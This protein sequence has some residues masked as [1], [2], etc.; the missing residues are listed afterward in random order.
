MSWKVEKAIA[1]IVK[2]F[3]RNK[4][5][6]FQE[7]ID[8]LKI[9]AENYTESKNETVNDNLLFA[10]LVSL[11]LTQNI[12][13]YGSIELAVERLRSDLELSFNAHV[14]TLA[15]TINNHNLL[16]YFNSIGLK[17]WKNEKEL[18]ENKTII[19]EHQKQMIENIKDSYSTKK[20]RNKLG[21]TVNDLL[22]NIK[23]YS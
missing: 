14:D 4:N 17:D 10:K 23:Y 9:V 8:A 15:S 16:N 11:C 6:I 3:Q 18:L 19:K 2:A 21:N 22:K 20:V 1:R 13:H 5:K 7:D 12:I